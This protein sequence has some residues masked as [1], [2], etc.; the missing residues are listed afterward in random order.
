MTFFGASTFF[1]KKSYN[2]TKTQPMF[3]LQNCK[4]L[5]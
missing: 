1:V 4:K 2:F 3:T 5:V